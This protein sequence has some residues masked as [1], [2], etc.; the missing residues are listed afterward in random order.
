M[1]LQRLTPQSRHIDTPHEYVTAGYVELIVN[2]VRPHFTQPQPLRIL[3]K[4]SKSP[5]SFV[6]KFTKGGTYITED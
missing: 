6:N 2:A 4:V 3:L 1:I 5:G